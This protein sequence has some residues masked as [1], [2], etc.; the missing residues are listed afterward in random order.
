MSWRVHCPVLKTP[1]SGRSLNADKIMPFKTPRE[2]EPLLSSAPEDE[3]KDGFQMAT[4]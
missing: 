4:S 1:G 2:R 3:P